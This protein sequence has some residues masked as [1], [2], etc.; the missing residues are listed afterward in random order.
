[1]YALVAVNGNWGSWSSPSACTKTCG[2]GKQIR[3]RACD[4]PSPQNGGEKCS[5][6]AEEERTC[7]M[8]PCKGKYEFV[9]EQKACP[10]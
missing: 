4:N 5:G 8:Q 9:R 7:N 10:V 6:K 3:R 2:G 1:M